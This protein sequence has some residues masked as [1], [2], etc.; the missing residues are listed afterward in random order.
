V[1]W[2]A[3]HDRLLYHHDPTRQAP[4]TLLTHLVGTVADRRCHYVRVVS[5]PRW[6]QAPL[7]VMLVEPRLADV[8]A[9][10][11]PVTEKA[12]AVPAGFTLSDTKDV[13][14]STE[15]AAA[16][17]AYRAGKLRHADMERGGPAQPG[18]AEPG[19]PAVASPGT[20]AGPAAFPA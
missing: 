17:A 9:R 7:G 11:L 18:S 14:P 10:A 20:P 6:P 3:V 16:S 5:L 19:S 15:E 2:T 12:R 4:S 8:V 13:P 1:P